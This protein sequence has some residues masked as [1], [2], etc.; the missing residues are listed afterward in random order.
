MRSILTRAGLLLVV[1]LFCLTAVAREPG[2]KDAKASFIDKVLQLTNHEREK[3][4]LSPLT[5]EPKLCS[6]ASWKADD[7]AERNYFEHADGNGRDFV[8]R[9]EQFGYYNWTYLGENIAAGQSTP[10]EVVQEWMASPGHRKN[11]LKP[12]YKEIGIG[13][14]A[15]AH[16][17]Y[18]HYWVQE[19]GT[20]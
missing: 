5:L 10:E 3:V 8:D 20:H 14:S 11:I 1:S 7:M 12:Q 2:S 9:A 15:G 16:G 17:Q 19:F 18:K 13:Y 6:S 4:G